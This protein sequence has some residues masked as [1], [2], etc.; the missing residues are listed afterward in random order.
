MAG[1]DSFT[2]KYLRAR[3]FINN[4]FSL[5]ILYDHLHCTVSIKGGIKTVAPGECEVPNTSTISPQPDDLLN[6]SVCEN[7][8]LKPSKTKKIRRCA[9]YSDATKLKIENIV[10]NDDINACTM[11]ILSEIEKGMKFGDDLYVRILECMELYSVTDLKTFFSDCN[12]FYNFHSRK[13]AAHH[14]CEAF[15]INV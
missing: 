6:Q 5:S 7:V 3:Q 4:E 1:V 15:Q 12:L 11:W 10:G 13:D 2:P 14:F 8:Y 9:N